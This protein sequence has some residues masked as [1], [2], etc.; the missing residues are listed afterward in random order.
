MRGSYLWRL[1]RGGRQFDK[2]E[3]EEEVSFRLHFN[4]QF[5]YALR[6]NPTGMIVHLGRYYEPPKPGEKGGEEE[7]HHEHHHH[8]HHG[9]HNHHHG[10]HR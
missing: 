6:H 10:D 1:F 3:E 5:L 9:D 4:R 2:T 7:H 8:Q